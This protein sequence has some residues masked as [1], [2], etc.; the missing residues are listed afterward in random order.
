[1]SYDPSTYPLHYLSPFRELASDN[2]LSD[3]F[4]D[5]E[6][7]E[8]ARRALRSLRV[9][10]SFGT[11]GTL[12]VTHV[13]IIGASRDASALERVNLST[14]ESDLSERFGDSL[15]MHDD[16]CEDN[17][18]CEAWHEDRSHLPYGTEPCELD[19]VSGRVRH[20]AVGYIDSVDVR[21]FGR[22]ASGA[23]TITDAW[24]ASVEWLESLDSYA[25]ADDDALSE[26]EWTELVEYLSGSESVPDAWLPSMMDG[27]SDLSVADVDSLSSDD[28]ASVVREIMS[29]ESVR[30]RA[31]VRSL[32]VGNGQLDLSGN[33]HYV[34]CVTDA[35][36][37][38]ELVDYYASALHYYDRDGCADDD[39]L[40]D[41]L[42]FVESRGVSVESL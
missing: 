23:W 38:G 11:S 40:S 8:L 27:L 42:A 24:R 30:V 35:S 29:T 41:V 1:M 33:V 3:T 31:Y 21:P 2:A 22:G 7:R 10:E 17:A 5:P 15:S 18:R 32:H 16:T 26:L 36:S 28:L 25:C 14:V 4:P 20:W 39:G 19:I 37:L 9:P 34:P 13:P 12:Y 6:D